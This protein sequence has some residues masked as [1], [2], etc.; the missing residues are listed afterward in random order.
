MR[1]Q[2][3]YGMAFAALAV[4]LAAACDRPPASPHQ[5]LTAGAEPLRSHFNRDV[6]YAR[7][8]LLAAPT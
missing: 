8:V 2:R 6:G 3:R 4:L 5:A 7:I 1:H